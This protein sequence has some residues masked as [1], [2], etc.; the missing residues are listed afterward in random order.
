M[1]LIFV[2]QTLDP[3]HPTLAQSLDLVRALA[4]RSEELVVLCQTQRTE[5]LPENVRVRTFEAR[6]RPL[7]VLRYLSA[8]AAELR[9]PPD[10]ILA[11]MV[12]QY[13]SLAWPLARVRRVPIL[14]WYTHWHAG[15]SLRLATRLCALALSV[16]R[17]SF[18]LDSPKV[19]GIG[20]AIDVDAFT[21]RG[22]RS[23]GPLRLLAL[24]RTARWKGLAT[25]LAG[26]ERADVHATLE[27]RGGQL[28]DDERQHLEELRHAAET[29]RLAGRVTFA[30]AVARAEV[31]ALLHGSDALVSPVEPERGGTLDKAVYEAA[32]CGIPVLTS[33]P[34]LRDWL[35]D[36]P[37]ELRFLPHDPDALA[38]A[39]ESFA[40]ASPEVRAET[41]RELRRRVVRDHSLAAWADTVIEI[42]ESSL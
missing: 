42:V 12:P 18:P 11:H 1:R 17:S 4:E 29:P 3:D 25:L 37:L 22:E 20:H 36:L 13:V 28:T 5:A 41:G 34:A 24:G 31:P 19:R 7:R 32:A 30:P 16:D 14:L 26:L 40:A 23:P 35:D 2:T 6:V 9:R 38:R 10:A 21:L 15:R 33:N 8:L 27:V 39:L